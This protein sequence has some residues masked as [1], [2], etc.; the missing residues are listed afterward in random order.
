G[1]FNFAS[2]RGTNINSYL[3][4]IADTFSGSA[5]DNSFDDNWTYVAGYIQ[6][7]W[8]PT[9][10]LTLNLGLRYEIQYGPYTN[11]FDTMPIR[12]L[13]AVGANTE[14]KTDKNNLGPRIGFAWDVQGNAKTVIRGGYGRYYDEIFQNITL[15]E[16]WS[17]VNSPTNFI[18]LSP[19]PFTPN[20][21][22]RNRDAIRRSLI[23]PTFA[24]QLLRLTSPDLQQPYSDQF[25]GGLS[26]QPTQHLG[27]DIDYVHALGKQEIHRWRINTAQN[28]NTRLSP[29]GVFARGLGPILVEGNRGHSKFDGV[30]L[31]GKYRSSRAEVIATYAWSKAENLANQFSSAV[32]ANTGKPINALAGLGG[33]RNAVR[34]IDPATGQMFSRNAFRSGSLVAGCSDH[35]GNCAKAAPG[36]QG[37]LAFFSWDAR[38]SKLFKFGGTRSFEVLFEVFNLTNHVNFDRDNYVQRFPASNFGHAT[39]VIKNSQRQAEGGIRFRF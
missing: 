5:G 6:D 31:T 22:V 30:Y 14:R 1:L 27:F 12:A 19:A 24:G 13:K 2:S 34:A 7:D 33:L 23:D 28:V 8:K 15:Y 39:A 25:N 20:D 18:S 16:Y 11:R 38:L 36:G 4:A 35:T 37:G 21:Y 9:R 26:L 17:Q 10:N 3:N 29:A 32:Q